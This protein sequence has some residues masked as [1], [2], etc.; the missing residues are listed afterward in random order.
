MLDSF[1]HSAHISF[2]KSY[3]GLG[4]KGHQIS[5]GIPVQEVGGG[6]FTCIQLTN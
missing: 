3:N 2:L 6:K 1:Y 5:L 4:W